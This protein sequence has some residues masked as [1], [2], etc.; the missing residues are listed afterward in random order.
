MWH[1]IL[2]VLGPIFGIRARAHTVLHSL[3]LLI[4]HLQS[5]VPSFVQACVY[6]FPFLPIF[7]SCFLSCLL[8]RFVSLVR[9]LS[10]N[11]LYS[12]VWFC[13]L[14]AYIALMPVANH[15][16]D[17]FQIFQVSAIYRVD[18]HLKAKSA[19]REW[20][21]A[22]LLRFACSNL[23]PVPISTKLSVRVLMHLKPWEQHATRVNYYR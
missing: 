17:A 5:F 13:D 2:L 19:R 9:Y 4:V 16:T 18:F 15:G 3:H 11:L 22:R 6:F 7:L 8:A 10:R 14:C 12:T 1:L 23:L 20:S 21:K